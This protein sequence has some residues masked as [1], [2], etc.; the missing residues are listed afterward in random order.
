MEKRLSKI[1][2]DPSH[3][4]SFSGVEKLWKAVRPEMSLEQVR[5]WLESEEGYTLHK[6]IRRKFP[7]NKYIVDN[8]DDLWQADLVDMRE[9]KS[10][11]DGF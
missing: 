7:R 4:A 9:L 10:E 6:P 2:Y 5:S 11:N 1:Y 8:M 3:P